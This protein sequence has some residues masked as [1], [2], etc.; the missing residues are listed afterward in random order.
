[1]NNLIL[2]KAP[3]GIIIKYKD[4]CDPNI[5]KKEFIKL[6]IKIIIMKN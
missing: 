2:D 5:K 3:K 1:M 6:I 4:L